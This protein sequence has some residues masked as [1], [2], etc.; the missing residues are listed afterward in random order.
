MAYVVEQVVLREQPT[1]VLRDTVPRDKTGEW[2]G[3]AF[4]RI[5]THLGAVAI[6]PAGPPFARFRFHED[7]VEVEAGAPVPEGTREGGGLEVSSLP[8][9]AAAVTLHVGP[10]ETLDQA[11]G[12]LETWLKEHGFEQSATFWEEYL[13]DPSQ[14]PDPARQRTRVV[15]PY[16][17]A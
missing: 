6:S 5:F 16:R 3:S 10:Y 14:E 17:T 8:A 2:L 4:G 15:M 12:A 13:T 11:Y 9:G 1:M 7:T